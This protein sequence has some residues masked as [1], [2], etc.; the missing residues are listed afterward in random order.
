M[1]DLPESLGSSK[2]SITLGSILDVEFSR[3]KTAIAVPDELYG[4]HTT[5][6]GLKTD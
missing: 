1:A 4:F 3:Q 6:F 2:W 5:L